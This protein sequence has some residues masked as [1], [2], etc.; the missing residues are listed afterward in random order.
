MLKYRLLT[1]TNKNKTQVSIPR[2]YVLIK[3]KG[4]SVMPENLKRTHTT[5]SVDTPNKLIPS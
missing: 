4:I 3:K 5:N 2:G 1:N